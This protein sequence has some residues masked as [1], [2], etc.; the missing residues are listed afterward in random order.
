MTLGLWTF[1]RCRSRP[2]IHRDQ[3]KLVENTLISSWI[4]PILLEIPFSTG[5]EAWTRGS[6]LLNS[7][8]FDSWKP[9]EASLL[10]HLQCFACWTYHRRRQQRCG[11][12]GCRTRSRHTCPPISSRWQP[13]FVE[14]ANAP[15]THES[16]LLVVPL[17]AG[18]VDG[19]PGAAI[20]PRLS[21]RVIERTEYGLFALLDSFA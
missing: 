6:A 3:L 4:A 17:D 21:Y 12:S 14:Q 9:S 7:P 20:V 13:E 1:A 18:G 15:A 11:S 2:S 8:T 19:A 10:V 16:G 5:L